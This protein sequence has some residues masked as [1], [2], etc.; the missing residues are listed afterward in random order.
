[1]STA[2]DPPAAEPGQQS[3][4]DKHLKLFEV[5][6]LPGK[7][8]GLIAL[9]DIAKGTRIV[10]EKPLFTIDSMP[11]AQLDKVIAAKVKALSKEEQRQFLALHNNSPGKHAFTGIA[12]TNCLPCGSDSTTGGIYLT[13]CLINHSCLPNAHNNWNEDYEEETIHATKPIKAGEEITI[14]YSKADP[15]HIRQQQLRNSF[16]FDC[17]CTLCSLPPQQLKLSD[18]RRV[19][20]QRLDDGIGDPMGMLSRPGACL[21]DCLSLLKLLEEEYGEAASIFVARACY[22]AF[23]ISVAHSDRSRASAFAERAYK[24]RIICEGEDSPATQRMKRLMENPASHRNF[25][26]CSKKWKGSDKFLPSSLSA[27][28]FESW[29]WRRAT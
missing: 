15:S 2:P 24:A 28:E 8:R 4:Q 13:I 11:P 21:A 14:D 10:R 12:K 1:M 25:G 20:I 23:Q 27:D 29:L 3:A 6:Q 18:D 22:D 7:G 26:A 19:Q 5:Q 9:C 17:Q 16:G